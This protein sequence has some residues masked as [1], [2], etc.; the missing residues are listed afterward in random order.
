MIQKELIGAVHNSMYQQWKKRGYATPVDTL[1]DCGILSKKSYDEW[2]FGQISYL[3]RCCNANLKTL[4]FVLHQMRI[5]ANKNG[6]K[7]SYCYYKQWGTKKKQGHK[8][9]I[10]L[11]FS[12][13][14]N[15]DIEKQYSTHFV[16]AEQ[17]RK[18]KEKI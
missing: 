9:V 15:E 2:R 4:S 14:G 10:P 11:R 1:M 17:I 16:D 18:L 3:E 5:F 8:P 6:W 13:S 7:S 12:K